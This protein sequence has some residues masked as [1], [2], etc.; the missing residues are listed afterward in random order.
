M[1]KPYEAH[2][3]CSFCGSAHVVTD[4]WPRECGYCHNTAWG[5]PIP[6]AVAIQP[7]IYG[8]VVVIRRNIEPGKGGLALPGGFMDNNESWQQSCS[9]ELFEE[10]GIKNEVA[11]ILPFR[12]HG[13]PRK[14]N[15]IVLF[16]VMKPLYE[17]ALPPF[18]PN[19]EVSERLVVYK[20]T[21]LIFETHQETLTDFYAWQ[22]ATLREAW[23]ALSRLVRP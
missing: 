19:D 23:Q 6:V 10:T 9:R 7:I 21:P 2:T 22:A 3:F 14:G 15:M 18:V 16:G 13:V 1:V 5:N 17:A 12:I 8:G 4:R 20:P 11:G